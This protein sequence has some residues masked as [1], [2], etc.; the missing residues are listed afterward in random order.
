MRVFVVI[1]LLLF[2][3]AALTNAGGRKSKKDVPNLSLIKQSV[4]IP[5][6]RTTCAEIVYLGKPH[7]IDSPISPGRTVI[8]DWKV[9]NATNQEASFRVV[10]AHGTYATGI[11]TVSANEILQ[12]VVWIVNVGPGDYYLAAENGVV[13]DLFEVKIPYDLTQ[14]SP[15]PGAVLVA[16]L[17]ASFIL[18]GVLTIV[19]FLLCR[20][21][22][23][24]LKDGGTTKLPPSSE[25]LTQSR[26]ITDVKSEII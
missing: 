25:S 20:R 23:G 3:F 4:I 17:V 6:L 22:D 18:A 15:P 5:L 14:S 19:V 7:G 21:R 2:A 9:S 11:A 16:A 13:S 1:A 8:I 24:Y 12:R 26:D 10:P